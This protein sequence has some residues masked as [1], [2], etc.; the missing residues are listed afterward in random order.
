[1][2]T[3]GNCDTKIPQV[4][5]LVIFWGS[6]CTLKLRSI[7]NQMSDYYGEDVLFEAAEEVQTAPTEWH[8]RISETTARL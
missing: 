6:I 1:M 3:V 8:C 4:L 2:E 5:S 7:S